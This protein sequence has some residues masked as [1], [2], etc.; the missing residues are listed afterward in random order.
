MLLGLENTQ[1]ALWNIYSQVAKPQQTLRMDGA[2][3]DAKALYNFHEAIINAMRPTLKEGVKSVVVAS[4]PRTDYA[5]VFLGHVRGHHAWLV[6]GAS[7]ATFAQIIGSA[8]TPHDVTTLTRTP[9]FRR[10]IGETT[11]E[12]TENL[13]GLLEKRLNASGAEPLVLYS[14]DEVEDK[15]LSPWTPGKPTPEY[16]LMADTYLPNSR[17]KGRLQRLMAIAANKKVQSRIVKADSP[18]GKRLL[19]LGGLVCILA[20]V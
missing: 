12:E 5:A 1:A 13:L 7:K 16:L 4:P 11:L 8:L 17:Q 2:R 3:T 18:A 20:P 10:I 6:Q 19:Q 15:I 9:E 14:L